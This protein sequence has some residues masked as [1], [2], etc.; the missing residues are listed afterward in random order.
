MLLS[1]MAM[2]SHYRKGTWCSAEH[3][4]LCLYFFFFFVSLSTAFYKIP[5]R[6]QTETISFRFFLRPK[7][8]LLLLLSQRETCVSVCQGHQVK[9][10]ST[11]VHP[12]KKVCVLLRHLSCRKMRIS[13]HFSLISESDESSVKTFIN[14]SFKLKKKMEVWK[15]LQGKWQLFKKGT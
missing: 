12:P 14:V 6:F 2:R 11:W 7:V 13:D 5:G 15:F 10:M 8:V 9:I 1:R 3:H 4:D